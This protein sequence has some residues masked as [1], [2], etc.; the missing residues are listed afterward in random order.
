MIISFHPC[1]TADVHII[2]GDRLPNQKERTLLSEADAIILPQGCT[3]EL[4]YTCVKTGVPI[5]PEYKYRFKYPGKIGQTK[6]FKELN[7]PHPCSISVDNLK[8]LLEKKEFF[9][10]KLPFFLKEN[11]KHEGEGVYFI[12]DLNEI[13][14][15]EN[16]VSDKLLVQ[17]FISCK[18]NVLRVVIIG[19]KMISYWTRPLKENQLVTTLSNNARVDHEWSPDL[20]EKGDALVKELILR[21]GINLAAVDIVFEEDKPFLL[22]INYYFGRKGLGGSERYYKLL[23][24]AVKEWTVQKGLSSKSLKLIC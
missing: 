7:L 11:M 10:R 8:E 19:D 14:K 5:F 23:F 3:E 13:K 20:Q 17:E 1:I 6:L 22:E 15:I 21:T 16:K 2:L 18:G 9:S 24:S 4:F 12:K